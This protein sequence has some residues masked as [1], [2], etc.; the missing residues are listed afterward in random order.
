MA[1]APQAPTGDLGAGTNQEAS[2]D[3]WASRP[4]LPLVL[5]G[6]GEL[7]RAN[8]EAQQRL[9][10]GRASQADFPGHPGESRHCQ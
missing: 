4:L 1:V 5:F 6:L 3:N 10:D 7:K 9:S 8:Q 2:L